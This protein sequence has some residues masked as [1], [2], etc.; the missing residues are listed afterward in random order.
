MR[1]RAYRPEIP[2]CLEERSLL[3]GV[4]G[5]SAHPVVITKGQVGSINFQIQADFAAF[6]R[7]HQI[8][9]LRNDIYNVAVA[10]PFGQVDGLGVRI[11]AIIT[12]MERQLLA[13]VPR[14]FI[15][16]ETEVLAAVRAELETR[17]QAGD[18]RVL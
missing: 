1:T 7:N 11:N 10:V 8:P 13:H 6:L 12:T 16:G 3:S 17:V 14:A 18:V 4:A 15:T 2:A 9:D 5:P